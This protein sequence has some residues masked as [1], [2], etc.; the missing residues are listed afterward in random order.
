M[1]EAATSP[2]RGLFQSLSKRV[3]GYRNKKRNDQPPS[4]P[5]SQASDSASESQSKQQAAVVK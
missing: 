4:S 1:S 2:K 3:S 5:G